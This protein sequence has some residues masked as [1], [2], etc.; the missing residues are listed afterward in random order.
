VDQVVNISGQVQYPALYEFR[1]NESIV[2]LIKLAGGFTY[3]AKKDTIELIRFLEDG[4]KQM[5]N[6][7]SV[8]EVTENNIYLQ[9]KDHVIVRQIP[10]YLI[11]H[12]L[13]ITGYV[14]YPGWYKI[15]KNTSTLK[16]MIEEEVDLE[17]APDRGINIRKM[18]VEETI[19]NLTGLL[20]PSDKND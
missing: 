14:R 13:E 16:E 5:S 4:K 19:P 20:I 10:E 8:Q 1:P 18:D 9:N 2:D 12:Y 6:Y 11:D 3:N 15:N 17:E 7:Y